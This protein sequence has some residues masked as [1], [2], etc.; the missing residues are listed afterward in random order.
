MNGETERGLWV[1]SI[2]EPRLVNLLVGRINK[3]LHWRD[4]HIYFQAA[5]RFPNRLTG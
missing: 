5:D 1:T 4:G 2:R 3:L